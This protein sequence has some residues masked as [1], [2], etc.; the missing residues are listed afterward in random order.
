MRIQAT[1]NPSNAMKTNCYF[2]CWKNI[3]LRFICITMTLPAIYSVRATLPE[4]DN[5]LYGL[6]V[7]SNQTVNASQTDIVIEARRT[8]NGPVIASY[9]MGDDTGIGNFYALRLRMES[10]LSVASS[11]ASTIGEI[12]QIYVRNNSVIL[13][14]K[15]H[16]FAERGEIK[17]VDFGAGTSDMDG[18]GLPDLWEIQHFGT[19]GQA[20]NSVNANG[21]TTLANFVAG[22]N[23]NDTNSVFKLNVQGSNN[24]MRVSFNAL[25]AEGTGYEG[26]ARRYA[27]LYRT[28]LSLG[29]W[30]EVTNFNDIFATNQT[31]TYSTPST[32]APAFFRGEVWIDVP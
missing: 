31:V 11:N 30:L 29:N 27:L 12:V 14:Q 8:T 18:N 10:V 5:V 26:Y 4:P 3:A 7:I 17:R 25:R 28:N 16:V 15:S 13:G 20:T 21:Q 6:I 23:P 9:R 1:D 22:T 32:G 24:V 2:R 19:S